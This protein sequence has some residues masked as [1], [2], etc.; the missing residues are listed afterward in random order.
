MEIKYTHFFGAESND[1]ILSEILE[2]KYTHFFGAESNDAI[3]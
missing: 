3:L 1:A 2:I